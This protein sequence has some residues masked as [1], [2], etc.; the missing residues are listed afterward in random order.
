MAVQIKQSS[1]CV[2]TSE[3]KN[4]VVAFGPALVSEVEMLLAKILRLLTQLVTDT[5]VSVPC[6]I[7]YN[8]FIAVNENL[9][10]LFC[11]HF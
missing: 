5:T 4:A 3:K 2:H 9:K 7:I 10:W 11:Y 8:K 1:V 6:L